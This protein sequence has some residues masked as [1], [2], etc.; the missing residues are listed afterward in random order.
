[1]EYSV[2]FWDVVVRLLKYAFA[3]L[4]IVFVALILPNNKLDWGEILILALTATCT[5][6]VLDLLSPPTVSAGAR[7]GVGL[8]DGFMMVGYPNGF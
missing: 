6:Y 1:M 7:Q 8:G 4:I 2:D 3:G 5:F